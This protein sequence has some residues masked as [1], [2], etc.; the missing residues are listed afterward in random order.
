ML[1]NFRKDG[2][3]WKKKNDGKTVKEAHEHLKVGDQ[4]RI[5]VYY[6][7][8]QEK[9]NFVRRCYWLLDK[10][11]E[12]IVLV[13]YREVLEDDAQKKESKEPMPLSSQSCIL[14]GSP[15][16]PT[17]VGSCSGN[18][19]KYGS[20]QDSTVLTDSYVCSASPIS[21]A[22]ANQI[23]ETMCIGNQEFA[24]NDAG[25]DLD[26][27]FESQ[28]FS[29][30]VREEAL[31][32]DTTLGTYE[33]NV[34]YEGVASGVTGVNASQPEPHGTFFTHPIDRFTGR[35]GDEIVKEEKDAA[36]SYIY[37]NSPL[38]GATD[39]PLV[40][41]FQS[42]E[43]FGK[44]MDSVLMDPSSEPLVKEQLQIPA[45]SGGEINSHLVD[46][47][48]QDRIF[49]VTEVLPLRGLATE[50]TKVLVTGCFHKSY[51]HLVE[52]RILC[53][54]GDT[55]V[56][57]EMVQAG[58]VRC[59]A[60]PQLS[61]I[62]SFYLSFDGRVP[63]SQIMSFEYYPAPSHSA[64][65]GI[66]APKFDESKWNDFEVKR[67]LAH[68]LFS[69]SSGVS[70]FT[71]K[72][73]PKTLNDAKRFAQSTLLHEKD[74]MSLEN[75]MELNEASFLKAN[76]SLLDLTLKTKLQEWLLEKL[77]EG[78]GAIVRDHQGQG[79]IHLCAVL[80]YRWAIHLITEAGISIDFRDASGWTALHW[81]ANFG[82]NEM[83]AVLLRQGGDPSLVSDPTPE[84]PGG[85]T[86]ADLAYKNG[87]S[88]LAAYL[89]EKGLTEHFRKM[90]VAGNVR[91]NL[92]HSNSIESPGVGNLTEE[93]LCLKDSLAAMRTA[94]DAASRIQEA[95]RQRSL[96]QRTKLAQETNPEAEA[97]RIVAAL[98]IQ[99]AFQ[100]HQRKKQ[101]EAVVRIQHKFRVWKARKD[102]L[103][104]RRQA[105]KIQA[106]FRGHQVRKQYR[107]IL[108]S[109]GVL[110]KV[111]L[112]WRLKRKGLRGHHMNPNNSADGKTE[113]NDAEED[114]FRI[115][116]KQAEERVERAVTRV[117]SMFRS[118]QARVEYRKMKQLYE[119]TE[120]GEPID[121]D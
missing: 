107:K 111:I 80:D 21:G 116:R 97:I 51:S 85:C 57:A 44:W 66:S 52:S 25:F 82:R 105:I 33:D 11:L 50:W 64:N 26:D 59:M 96:K 89:A 45:S 55:S 23:N 36:R 58:V 121:Q 27:L 73:S 38:L 83:V 20:P 16:V 13:H 30:P 29:T 84:Y 109:V 74:W 103:N 5:H 14:P 72:V 3:V 68:L 56:P 78:R 2:H 119:Q 90:T 4:E 43:S 37:H 67:R 86:P 81:A 112:R 17:S 12:R 69:T 53:V 7:H 1:R 99:H 28:I 117:Q 61:G 101:I 98:K 6:A 110:E 42:Q 31:P 48:Q 79:V 118:H 95:F 22:R 70:I 92:Q 108:W 114:F 34:M 106:A 75:S 88:G 35:D 102:F 24:I 8:G 71:S 47:P 62:Y 9:P 113:E 41:A 32:G 115:S 46:R 91:G 19:V 49:S 76:V 120:S 60:P 65:N 54:F 18:S 94:A 10:H 15:L 87:Y 40:N 93:D 77:I 39:M 100:R 104:M 63:I